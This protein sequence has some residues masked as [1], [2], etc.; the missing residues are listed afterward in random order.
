LGDIVCNEI[1]AIIMT[2]NGFMLDS[3]YLAFYSL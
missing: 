3:H 1:N 2:A